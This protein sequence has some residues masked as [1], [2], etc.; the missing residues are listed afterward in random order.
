MQTR[1]WS[2]LAAYVLLLVLILPVLAACGGAPA[3]QNEPTAGTT[4]GEQAT[5]APAAEPTAAPAAPAAEATAEPAAEPTAEPA[6]G[7]N[8]GT[9]EPGV[10]RINTGAEPE[11]IDPQ[12]ASFV[13][14]IQ[15]IMMAY[16]PLMSFDRDMKPVPGAAESVEVSDDGLVYT[17]K[18]RPNSQ[19][20]DGTPLTAQNF[21][22]A[23]KRLANPETA[24]QYQSL[25]CGIIKG[26]SEWSAAACQGLTMTDTMALDLEQLEADYGVKAVDDNTLT[27]ELTTPAPY[28][29][30][31][32]A[33]WIGA[34]VRQEDAEKGADWW[35]DAENYIGNGPFILAEWDHGNKTTWEPNP[36]YQGPLGPVKLKRVEYYM[37]NEG[38]VAFQAYQN[39]ELDMLGVSPED[40]AT[41]ESDPTLSQ[42][43]VNT[44]GS[45]TFYF[46]FNLTTPP[47]DNK[48]V[49]QAF[50]Q[51]IDREAY[52]R[53][54]FNGIG[55]PTQVFIP[56]G[57]P[58]YQE[59]L[60]LWDFNPEAA[61]Q[62]LA[63]A[64]FPNGE[65]LPEIK[66]TYS[67][68]ARNNARFEWVAN[69]FKENLGIDAVLDPIDPTAFAGVTKENPPQM[70]S[71]GWCADYPDQQNWISLFQTNGLL[72]TRVGYSNT[73]FDELIKQA[74]VEQDPATRDDLYR[75]A[76]QILIEDAPVV[77]TF[78]DGGPV[79]V[80][81]YVQG[82]SED[83]ITP[84]DYW[85]GFFNLPNVDV[86][87]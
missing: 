59:D 37:I 44:V 55:S 2:R 41:V 81:P 79:L 84:I 83:T 38:Q 25:P 62:A 74:D 76:E 53:D 16:Q 9:A 45:C 43:T 58:G 86:Q 27:I 1:N 82:V 70:F 22:Y 30:S 75:Q 21:E 78:N 73:E 57:F 50:A 35:Y 34:P 54:I 20:S 51:A 32:A 3:A 28:F 80:K 42:E 63:D 85:L 64:G 49:R 31:M 14:E 68:S 23:W 19:Y 11:N 17:F 77:F 46:G 66:L 13:D 5:T 8:T 40:L 72:S 47:F 24:G 12:Q 56:P 65:G 36:N 4:A 67:A 18:I 48:Q 6:A 52:V 61:K 33:L 26:Y 60:K 39:G 71:L 69:Q 15:Y 29:L 10:L 87:P 7:A